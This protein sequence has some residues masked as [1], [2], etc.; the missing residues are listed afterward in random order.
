STQ[1]ETAAALVDRYG[2]KVFA[3]HGEDTETY[4][5]HIDALA[6]MGPQIT[7]DDGADVISVIHTKRTD[8]IPGIIGGTEETTTGVIRLK[9]LEEE[10]KLAFPIVAVNEA[11][12]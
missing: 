2:A 3:I 5:R 11:Q 1:D 7:M 12:T 8:L 10:G 4:Y 9:A 6:D